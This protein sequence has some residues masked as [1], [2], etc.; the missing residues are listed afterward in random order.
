MFLFALVISIAAGIVGPRA[1]LD[2]LVGKRRDRIRRSIPDSLDLLVVCVE[3][4]VG[5]DSALV[6]VAR[7]MSDLH[8]DLS[9]EL[10]IVNRTMNAG[11]TRE[12][13][14]HGLFERTGV[15]ELRGLAASMIQSERLGTSVARVLRVYAETLRRK[16][17]Q[18]AERRAAEA[19]IKMLLPLAVFMLPA[20]FALILAPAAFSLAKTMEGMTMQ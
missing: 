12:E 10:F 15:D 7:D 14:M 18:F 19:S 2:R 17:K 11:I 4:G 5:L 3:A 9:A 16:R 6:R 8:P 20:L 1:V 13:A